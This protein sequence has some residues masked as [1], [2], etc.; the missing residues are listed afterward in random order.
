MAPSVKVQ[1][2]INP[3]ESRHSSKE[4]C[5]NPDGRAVR[6]KLRAR[7]IYSGA[8]MSEKFLTNDEI[9]LLNKV[10][11]PGDFHRNRW[12]VRVRKDDSGKETVIIDFPTKSVDDRM[13]LP[14]SM[15]AMINEILA[16][17]KTKQPAK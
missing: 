15:V 14:H 10:T 5:F 13:E 12:H 17:Q 11:E 9:E 3:I 2:R 8:E 16:E 4:S 7:F 1:E 6:P